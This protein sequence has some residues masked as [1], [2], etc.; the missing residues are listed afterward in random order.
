[1]PDG[2]SFT[3]SVRRMHLGGGSSEAGVRRGEFISIGLTDTGS[4]IEPAHLER[5]FEPYFTTKQSGRG[6]GLG[7]SQVYGFAKQA[8]GDVDVTSLVGRGTKFTIYLPLASGAVTAEAAAE[9]RA[10]EQRSCCVLLIEDDAEVAE[11]LMGMLEELG[12]TVE[13]A[14]NANEGLER[15][16]SAPKFDRVICDIVMPGG[17]GGVEFARVVRE[18]HPQLPILLITGYT[19]KTK[20]VFEAGFKVLKKPFSL[21]ELASELRRESDRDDAVVA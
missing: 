9:P 5:I 19:G 14:A 7:L 17:M 8:G 11:V 18:S 3:V 21:S 13:R 15:L 12:H 2:G 4:G 6:T 16:K 20:E 10:A 1:M